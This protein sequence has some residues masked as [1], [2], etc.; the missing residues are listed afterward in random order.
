[1][2][3]STKLSLTLADDLREFFEGIDE[4]S[5]EADRSLAA[6]RKD[7]KLIVRSSL[8]FTL[9][10][11]GAQP[12]TLTSIDHFISPGD[13]TASLSLP[14]SWVS[15]AEIGSSIVFYAGVPGAL[16]DLSADFAVALSLP[17]SGIRLDADLEPEFLTS[18][19]SGLAE[20][21]TINR[22]I[23]VLMGGGRTLETA[24]AELGSLAEKWQQS[25][26]TS[27]TRLLSFVRSS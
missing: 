25:M 9:R 22:A 12:V 13:I 6:L 5:F 20:A 17:L 10:L 27:A 2:E 3:L 1:M 23:G 19:V 7:L 4:P 26:H 16:V 11:G 18:G 21:S 14:L 24:Q 15:P 8:G